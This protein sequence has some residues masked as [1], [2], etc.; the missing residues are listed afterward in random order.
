MCVTQVNLVP[1]KAGALQGYNVK[2]IYPG[3][4]HALAVTQDGK[5][6]AW[7]RPTYG[8]L[9]RDDAIVDSDTGIS[10]GEV[11]VEGL[12]GAPVGAAAGGT[13]SGCYS[14]EMCGLWLCGMGSTGM[15]A[16]GADDDDDEK[17]MTKVK[18]TKVF[19]EVSIKHL[20]FGGQHVVMLIEPCKPAK[21]P[22][23]NKNQ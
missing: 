13:V 10:P 6:I 19:N 15:L 5:L 1:K 9:A 4:H 20:E 7:G 11:S 8:R 22:E 16:K 2:K 17:L 21:A 18:R 23:E 3:D 14:N 12:E